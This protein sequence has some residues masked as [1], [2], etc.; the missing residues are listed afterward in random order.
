MMDNSGDADGAARH[1]EYRPA[2]RIFGDDA[3]GL[4]EAYL[5][6]ER[7]RAWEATHPGWSLDWWADFG[8]WE[9]RLI[10]GAERIIICRHSLDAIDVRVKEIL[11]AEV[12]A[13]A[14]LAAAV[15]AVWGN[16]DP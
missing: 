13:A 7:F 6:A 10:R 14:I 2:W 3:I 4:L 12:K 16:D 15:A 1:L 9:A 11:A 5:L 8:Y